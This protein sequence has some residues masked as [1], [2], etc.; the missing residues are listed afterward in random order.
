MFSRSDCFGNYIHNWFLAVQ[1][2]LLIQKK[3]IL[4]GYIQTNKHQPF[5]MQFSFPL[6][7]SLENCLCISIIYVY[8]FHSKL[9]YMCVLEMKIQ[10]LLYKETLENKIWRFWS[11]LHTKQ[12]ANNA[13]ILAGAKFQTQLIALQHTMMKSC[14]I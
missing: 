12:N 13:V 1:R 4:V 7:I 14:I 9:N 5:R 6:I 2:L 11:L 3:N 8:L 10:T